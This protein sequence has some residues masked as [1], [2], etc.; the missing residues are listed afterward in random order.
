MN[1]YKVKW[2]ERTPKELRK[3][4]KWKYQCPELE[5]LYREEMAKRENEDDDLKKDLEEL[6]Q[7]LDAL[8]GLK[9]EEVVE[10]DDDFKKAEEASDE[11]KKSEEK[12]LEGGQDDYYHRFD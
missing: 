6:Q 4:E 5:N 1:N 10:E 2:T 11:D 9:Q 12:L 3:V 7:K 8:E